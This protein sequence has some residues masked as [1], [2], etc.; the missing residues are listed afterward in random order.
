MQYLT[1]SQVIDRFID[2]R[3]EQV[4]GRYVLFSELQQEISNEFGGGTPWMVYS[5]LLALND[6]Y[7]RKNSLVAGVLHP[8]SA[9]TLSLTDSDPQEFCDSNRDAYQIFVTNLRWKNV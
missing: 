5:L 2:T 9:W 6:R 8:K 7:Y 3:L 4:S 1:D